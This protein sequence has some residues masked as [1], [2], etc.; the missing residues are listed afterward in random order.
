MFTM[1]KNAI[2][3]PIKAPPFKRKSVR[4]KWIS[5]IVINRKTASHLNILANLGGVVM[6]WNFCSANPPSGLF[7][8]MNLNVNQKVGALVLF[9]SFSMLSFAAVVFYEFEQNLERENDLETISTAMTNHL[10]ADMMHDA[11]RSDVLSATL[12]GIKKDTNSGKEVLQELGNHIAIFR[13]AIEKNE[14]LDL[15][16]STKSALTSVEKPLE[17]Y[18]TLAADLAKKAIQDPTA[19]E[20]EMVSFGKKFQDLE[21]SMSTVSGLIQSRAET[22]KASSEQTKKTFLKFLFIGVGFSILLLNVVGWIVARSI[23]RSFM[24]LIDRLAIGANQIES[25]SGHI[26]SSSESLASSTTEQAASLEETSASLEEIASMTKNNAENSRVAKDLTGTMREVADTGASDMEE[27]AQ[28]M[29]AIKNSSNNIAKII[30]TIDE[31]AFQTNIL[32]LN[33]AVEAA[34]AGEAGMGFAVV[35]EEVRNLALRS[36]S[37][38]R[39]TAE[40]I[41]DSIQK[42]SAGVQINAKVSLSLADIVSKARQADQL[43]AQISIAS[44]EQSQGIDQINSSVSQMDAMTQ[45]NAA[46]A[47]ESANVSADLRN[48]STQLTQLVQELQTLVGGKSSSAKRSSKI[49]SPIK[50]KKT[51]VASSKLVNQSK[52]QTQ[53]SAT[54]ALPSKE[55]QQPT[56]RDII[57][58]EDEFQDF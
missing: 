4:A 24:M 45:N 19:V 55:V 2:K 39:E 8:K 12:S 52:S 18:T 44:N 47:E 35:A 38:A 40:K 50:A 58:L 33:A 16:D 53:R 27:M 46:G 51:Q 32:A 49:K 22:L 21:R 56:R 36:A 31:I 23:P 14:K 7:Q 11:L 9:A 1:K 15:D 20:S 17:E 13:G 6:V 34:R 29:A 10:E 37:A 5:R 54:R 25:A 43:V 41:E 48:Q 30:K 26:A 57:P 42:S 3:S 28:A